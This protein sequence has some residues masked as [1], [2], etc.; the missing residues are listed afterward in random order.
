M[1]RF[2]R[3]RIVMLSIVLGLGSALVGFCDHRSRCSSAR[4]DRGR[5]FCGLGGIYHAVHRLTRSTLGS[6]FAHQRRKPGCAPGATGSGGVLATCGTT[7]GVLVAA[8]LA[9]AVCSSCRLPENTGL[10]RRVAVKGDFAVSLPA[11]LL[12]SG[13][14][15]VLMQFPPSP[16]YWVHPHVCREHRW[17]KSAWLITMLRRRFRRLAVI[18]V[19]I[20][21]RLE[22]R[23]NVVFGAVLMGGSWPCAVSH[24]SLTLAAMRL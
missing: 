22:L 8:S 7:H 18:S 14:M 6:C 24:T 2:R 12:A 13:A 15:A 11:S 20:A 19:R 21:E 5:G 10:P 16:P 3:K 23:C 1:Q 4:R 9:P 17:S